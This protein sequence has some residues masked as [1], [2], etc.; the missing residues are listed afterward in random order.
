[1]ERKLFLNITNNN[2]Y[3]GECGMVWKKPNSS[4]CVSTISF[5]RLPDL[6]INAENEVHVDFDKEL[7]GVKAKL[8]K[9]HHN[10]IAW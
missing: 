5:D 9:N 8:R 10:I 6:G 4:T 2:P 1:M 7:E 3:R